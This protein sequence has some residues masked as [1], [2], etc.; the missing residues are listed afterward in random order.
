M[1]TT[2]QTGSAQAGAR[3]AAASRDAVRVL[4]RVLRDPSET[5]ASY[6][7]IGEHR[8]LDTGIALAIAFDVAIVL[9]MQIG[10]RKSLYALAPLVTYDTTLMSFL[11]EAIAAAIPA[12]ALFVVLAITQ[13]VLGTKF[14]APRVAFSTGVV[15]LPAAI[16][17][18]AAALLGIDSFEIALLLFVAM[19]S[20]TTLLL[21]SSCRDVLAIPGR[22]VAFAIPLIFIATGWLTTVVIRAIA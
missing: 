17:G 19:V 3:A 7:A 13:R 18:L 16:V 20:Y 4:A 1:E 22:R 8:G 2:V 11:K 5:G 6:E 12:L 10:A 14:D 15:L 21:F 9:A